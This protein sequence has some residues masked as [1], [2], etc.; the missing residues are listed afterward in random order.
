MELR[1]TVGSTAMLLAVEEVE[2]DEEDVIRLLLFYGA[3]MDA[4]NNL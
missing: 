2:V 1:R 3:N 4:R